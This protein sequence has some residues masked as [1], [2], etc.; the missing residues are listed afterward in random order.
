MIFSPI[1]EAIVL[2]AVPAVF[3]HMIMIQVM[4]KAPVRQ[5]VAV[6]AMIL[7]WTAY[8]YIACRTGFDRAAVG[9]FPGLPLVYLALA[10]LLTLRFREALLGEG[11]PQQLLIALQLFRPI[12]L[13]F[14]LENARGT[15]PPLFAHAAGWGDLMAGAVALYVLVRHP[16]GPVP[17]R[18]VILVAAV[19]LADFTSAFFL[20]FTSS[21]SPIQLFAFDNPNRVI[22]YPLGLIPMFL[23]PYAVM[24]HLLSL[25]QMLRDRRQVQA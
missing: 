17:E 18:L 22:E 20:G 13:V 14:V 16:V 23:V 9:G 3:W 15:L 11:V 10:A 12:G 4:G 8:A 1:S 5:L 21:A 24:A 19:G 2:F 7:V 6:G 25:A